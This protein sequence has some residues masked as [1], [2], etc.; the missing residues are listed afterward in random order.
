M[1][2]KAF[3][4]YPDIR[5]CLGAGQHAVLFKMYTEWNQIIMNGVSFFRSMLRIMPHSAHKFLNTTGR[6]WLLVSLFLGAMLSSFGVMASPSVALFYGSN[7]PLDE[8]K[9]FDVVVVDPDQPGVR[10]VSQLNI[11]SLKFPLT[12]P[13]NRRGA[14]GGGMVGVGGV[15]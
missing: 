7:P 6:G 10:C 14:D 11:V 15:V 8:L 13:R 9:A 1:E 4:N 2:Y 3:T 5:V 12:G